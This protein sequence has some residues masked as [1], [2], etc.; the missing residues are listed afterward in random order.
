M[1]QF[2]LTLSSSSNCE[3][4]HTN[5]AS[6]F[7]VHL[8]RTIELTGQWEVA[9]FEVIIPCTLANLRSSACH[10]IQ[11]KTSIDAETGFPGY[12]GDLGYNI[13]YLQSKC[14]NNERELI[15][16]VNE[17]MHPYINCEINDS[18]KVRVMVGDI[19]DGKIATTC[20]MSAELRDILGIPRNIQPDW[21]S[22]LQ[23]HARNEFS[24]YQAVRAADLKRGVSSTLTICTDLIVEQ[25]FNNMHERVLR[26]IH[27][28]AQNYKAGFTKK[29]EFQKLIFLPVAKQKIETPTLYIKDDTGVEA[30]FAHGTLTVVLLFRRVSYG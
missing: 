2:Y 21:N 26:V 1:E 4:R 17:K 6:N 16:H 19:N 7:R 29:Y 28:G 10:I 8:G 20:S 27:T 11:E 18:N 22:I 3:F 9:L 23:P 14:Y 24:I 25:S 30:S 12:I 13:T 15:E 5:K